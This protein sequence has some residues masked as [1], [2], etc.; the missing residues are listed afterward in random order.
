M[1][2]YQK[3]CTRYRYGL[4]C[5]IVWLAMVSFYQAHKKIP[6]NLNYLGDEYTFDFARYREESLFKTIV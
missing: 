1:R 6:E 2:R 4:V 3:K 5:L